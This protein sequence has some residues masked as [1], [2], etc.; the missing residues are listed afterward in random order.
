MLETEVTLE[1][2]KNTRL[3][4]LYRSSGTW[5]TQCEPEGFRRITYYLDRPDVLASFKVHD[6]AP[7]RRWRR[8]CWP[9]ATSSSRATAGDGM[10]FAVWE[11]PLPQAGL[12]LRLVAGDLGSIHDS[13]TTA[14]GRK[15]AL[16]IYCTHG[17]EEQCL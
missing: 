7:T 3:M 12:P 17:K 4:G 10:H 15:V 8:C 14:S 11:D 5:C 1:P 13:F 6:D 16:G 9:M 2:E